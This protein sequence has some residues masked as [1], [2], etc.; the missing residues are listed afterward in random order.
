MMPR[1]GVQR[2]QAGE[3]DREHLEIFITEH[4]FEVEWEM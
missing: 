4:G 2:A 1:Q 3:T